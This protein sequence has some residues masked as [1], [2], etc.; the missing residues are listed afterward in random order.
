MSTFFVSSCTTY[1][2]VILCPSWWRH[3]F[4]GSHNGRYSNVEF[5]SRVGTLQDDERDSE[6][7]VCVCSTAILGA[8]RAHLLVAMVPPVVWSFPARSQFVCGHYGAS[9]SLASKFLAHIVAY[10]CFHCI[11]FTAEV[12]INMLN[13]HPVYHSRVCNRLVSGVMLPSWVPWHSWCRKYYIRVP[14][15]F[16]RNNKLYMSVLFLGQIPLL[17][18]YYAVI[19]AKHASS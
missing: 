16:V 5:C 14:Q 9:I 8:D 15:M 17:C 10:C 2:N 4:P 19:N 11:L 12:F 1:I 13:L 6:P 7:A 3:C 18:C